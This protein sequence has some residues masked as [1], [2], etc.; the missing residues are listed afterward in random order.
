MYRISVFERIIN[1][2]IAILN[3]KCTGNS[4]PESVLFYVAF[5]E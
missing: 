1:Q 4:V 3:H 2:Y 5:I